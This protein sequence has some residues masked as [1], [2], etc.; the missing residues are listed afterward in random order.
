MLENSP[1]QVSMVTPSEVCFIG[2]CGGVVGSTGIITGVFT[3]VTRCCVRGAKYI[4]I[5]AVDV[6]EVWVVFVGVG[7]IFMY[8][9]QFIL[10]IGVRPL[11]GVLDRFYSLFLSSVLHG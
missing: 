3:I 7:V 2:W 1:S 9:Y 6:D 8:W 5:S 4:C 10:L 11:H